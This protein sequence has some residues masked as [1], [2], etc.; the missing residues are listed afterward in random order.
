MKLTYDVMTAAAEALRGKISKAPEVGLILGSGLGGLA[1]EISNPVYVPYDTLEGFPVSTVEGHAGRFVIGE[2]EGRSVIAMQ[3]RFHYY[4]GYDIG[5]VAM[6]VYVM[7]LL[8]VTHLLL[9]NAAGG[10]NT[11]YEPGDLMLIE[12][13]LNLSG[14]NPLIGPN[15]ERFGPRFPDASEVYDR[16]L[17]A[18]IRALAKSM[19]IRLQRGVYAMSPG[20]SYETPAEVRMARI[21]GADAV[22]MSTVP[23]ALVA[24]HCGIKTVGISCITNMAAGILDQPLHHSEVVETAERVKSTFTALV[25]A[26]VPILK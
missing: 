19:G 6:P 11:G 10:V 15:D 23:E 12:D 9:T 24:N 2:F 8:G 13:H 18:E 21:I 5:S 4:E 7:K 3:G 1:D 22:G 25:K 14:H 20:P 16:A 26:V 17:N